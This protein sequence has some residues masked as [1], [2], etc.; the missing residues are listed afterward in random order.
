LRSVREIGHVL[1]GVS[2]L[3]KFEVVITRLAWVVVIAAA[4]MLTQAP[5]LAA[6]RAWMTLCIAAPIALAYFFPRVAGRFARRTVSPR[7]NTISWLALAE[8]GVAAVAI[9]F[10]VHPDGSLAI[11]AGAGFVLIAS[12]VAVALTEQREVERILGVIE[13]ENERELRLRELGGG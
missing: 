12:E 2:T 5:K 11:A 13:A 10:G 4:G 6:S 3:R 7:L 1:E 8:I 9:T